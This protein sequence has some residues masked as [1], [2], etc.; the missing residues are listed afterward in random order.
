MVW[1]ASYKQIGIVFILNSNNNNNN[2][3]V[4]HSKFEAVEPFESPRWVTDATTH[5]ATGMLTV[6]TVTQANNSLQHSHTSSYNHLM[7]QCLVRV[8]K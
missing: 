3:E 4:Y 6:Q 8:I 2:N 7:R 1:F 5:A